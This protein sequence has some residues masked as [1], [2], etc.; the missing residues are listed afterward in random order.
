MQLH[1]QT[2]RFILLLIFYLFGPILTL[3]V[4]GGIVLRHLPANARHWEQT[5]T[6]QTGLHWEIKSVEFRSPGFVRLHK[7]EIKDDTGKDPVF[8]A[9]QIDIRRTTDTSWDK[10]FPGIA[11][12]S[13]SDPSAW[14]GLTA[15]IAHSLPSF[16]S[17]S[18]LWQITASMA[19]LDFRGYSSENSA[20]LVQNMLRKVVARFDTL[21][22]VPVQFIFEKLYVAS[23]HSQ[24]RD[25]DRAA[26]L[27]RLVQGNIYRTA[28]EIR[29]D[30]SFEIK[31]I[32]DIDRLHLSFV[33]SPTETLDIT[34]RTG[35]QP[36]P[37]DLAAVF[38]SSFKHFSGGTFVGEFTQSTR[39]GHNSQTI[40]LNNVIFQNVPLTPLVGP[41][42]DFAVV[43]TI[44]DLRFNEAV[45]GAEGF[46]VKGSLYVQNGAIETALF[47]RCVGNFDLKV[48][49]STILD[50]SVRMIPF[51]ESAILFQMQ[52][53]GIDF[54]PDQFWRDVF[55]H[56]QEGDRTVFTVHF[57]ERRQTVSYHEFMSVFA[58]DS[59]PTMPL[60]PG[61]QS[62][63]PFVPIQ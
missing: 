52:Q 60:T 5:L 62:V 10:I 59:A 20:L 15:A 58:P 36:I 29:S 48:E 45:F 61:L 7:V 40:R 28:S 34:L 6:Q 56:Y 24:K 13:S 31:D 46:N 11:T 35:K 41:Y 55:M 38:Y 17:E 18:Q 4:I 23:E 3:G 1:E 54:Q 22:D 26:D 43:G 50:S 16:G 37:C 2:Q 47:H 25:G 9:E 51:S 14:S 21:A 44:A 39:G 33:L 49:P 8:Y 57:P 19:I 42:T 32:S 63:L 12:D 53:G 27:F 30:W